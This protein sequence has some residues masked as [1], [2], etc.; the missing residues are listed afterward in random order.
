[1]L[2]AR[3]FLRIPVNFLLGE[4]VGLAIML[5]SVIMIFSSCISRKKYLDIV[6]SR[7]RAENRLAELTSEISIMKKD[8][9][10]YTLNAESRLSS[11]QNKIDSLSLI[12]SSL[13][14][15][16]TSKN[17]NI[18]EQ[19]FNFQ[20]E[21]SKLNLLIGEK[22]KEIRNLNREINTMSL[23]IDDLNRDVKNATS[24][25]KYPYGYVKKLEH[26]IEI[27]EAEIVNLKKELD[28]AKE[29]ITV[30]TYRLDSIKNIT[31]TPESFSFQAD[32]LP[33]K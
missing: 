1:M 16:I 23:Q 28:S 30:L 5:C 14:T 15:D 8:F 18:E 13:N 27:R 26:K 25:S 7:N 29:N 24:N 20:V 21:R 33:G 10:D 9:A 19:G 6:E 17:D 3:L 4:R 31:G 32:T 11:G 2:K 22:D 12:I